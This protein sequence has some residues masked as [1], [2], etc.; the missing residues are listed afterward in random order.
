MPLARV[1]HVLVRVAF[2]LP[3]F[4]GAH[5]RLADLC[6]CPAGRLDAGTSLFPPLSSLLPPFW[7]VCSTSIV[8]CAYRPW[9]VCIRTRPDIIHVGSSGRRVP[10]ESGLDLMHFD[11]LYAPVQG[12][13]LPIVRGTVSFASTCW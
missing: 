1:G 2:L 13:G 11:G 10:I 7:A 4:C 3:S 9:D 6:V 8:T 12:P 5:N